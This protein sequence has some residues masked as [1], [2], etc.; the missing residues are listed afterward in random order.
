LAAEILGK[1]RISAGIREKDGL[2]RAID[3]R[4]GKMFSNYVKWLGRCPLLEVSLAKS[5]TRIEPIVGD[6]KI[7]TSAKKSCVE[8][9]VRHDVPYGLCL[10]RLLE[11]SGSASL[12]DLLGICD[13]SGRRTDSQLF[14]EAAIREDHCDGGVLIYTLDKE[15][16]GQRW[17]ACLEP[18]EGSIGRLLDLVRA[19]KFL[20]LRRENNLAVPISLGKKTADS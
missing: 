15:R 7:T 10:E 20:R 8:E 12:C 17:Y 9:E 6:G 19:Q 18:T 13:G 11:P 5:R 3:E 4:R 1:Q 14:G 2:I 16:T